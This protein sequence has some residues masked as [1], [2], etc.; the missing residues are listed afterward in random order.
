MPYQLS[1]IYTSVYLVAFA[2]LNLKVR[3][4]ISLEV[5]DLFCIVPSESGANN[6]R[7]RTV[8]QGNNTYV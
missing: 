6:T 2:T 1:Y 5:P 7:G 4:L 8:I 3:A